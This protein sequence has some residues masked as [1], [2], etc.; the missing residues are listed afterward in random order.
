M[1]LLRHVLD[2]T[3]NHRAACCLEK[4][5]IGCA[6]FQDSAVWCQRAKQ[7]NQPA[8][9]LQRLIETAHDVAADI[10]GCVG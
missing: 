5:W 7:S 6:A 4:L 8:D 1:T 10:A 3:E 9:V 2:G